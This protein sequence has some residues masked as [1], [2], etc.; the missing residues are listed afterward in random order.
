MQT[1]IEEQNE[2]FEDART[3]MNDWLDCFIKADDQ[4]KGM[5]AREAYRLFV[6]KA[7][8]NQEL[9]QILTEA[10]HLK[11]TLQQIFGGQNW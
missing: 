1:H 4:Y 2:N 7:Q 5:I 9:N 10:I 6:L 3:N 11:D 8:G